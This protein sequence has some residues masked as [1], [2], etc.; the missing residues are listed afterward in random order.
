MK[1]ILKLRIILVTSLFALCLLPACFHSDEA[2]KTDFSNYGD[3]ELKLHVNRSDCLQAGEPLEIEFTTQNT[4]KQPVSFGSATMPVLD[5]V[6]H[7]PGS[8]Q[9]AGSWSEQNPS[10]VSHNVEWQPGKVRTIRLTW[11]APP[12]NFFP[13]EEMYVGSFGPRL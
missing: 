1:K 7:E 10:L 5:I 3:I 4:G 8:R 9:L 12:R 2:K 6:I 11:N 13:G